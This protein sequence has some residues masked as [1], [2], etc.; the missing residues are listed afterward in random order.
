M[1]KAMLQTDLQE[2]MSKLEQ[3]MNLLK[4]QQQKEKHS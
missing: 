4:I 3:V 1:M 2:I